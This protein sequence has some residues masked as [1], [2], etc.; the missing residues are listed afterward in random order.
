VVILACMFILGLLNSMHSTIPYILISEYV[1]K[2]ERDKYLTVMFMF[3]SFSAIIA[4]IFFYFI[5]N[6]K[7]FLYFNFGYGGIFIVFSF[8]LYESPRFLYSNKRYDEARHVL[9]KISKLNTGNEMKIKFE[10]EDAKTELESSETQQIPKKVITFKSIFT[11]SKMR[12]YLIILALI[13][14]LVAF[15]FYALSFMIKYLKADIYMMNSILF[16]SEVISYFLSTIIMKKMGKRNVM[17]VSFL[18]SGVCFFAFY[19]FNLLSIDH[20]AVIIILSFLA[21]F[22]SCVILNVSSIYTNE[23]FPTHLRGRSTAICSFL[24]K[25]GG[26]IAPMLVDVSSVTSVVSGSTCLLAMLILIPLSNNVKT[27]ELVDEQE[28]KEESIPNLA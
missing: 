3:E 16:A 5:Q 18:L 22:G 17:I 1:S 6:W 11:N 25:F 13:W 20:I 4:T 14:F 7:I 9:G 23:S 21:R 12:K 24:G 28:E 2:D 10:K 27:E 8:L 15:A 26:I 19:V